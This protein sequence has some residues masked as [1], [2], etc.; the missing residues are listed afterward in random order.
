MIEKPFSPDDPYGL[1]P[2]DD[3]DVDLASAPVLAGD[4]VV[5]SENPDGSV[6]IEY[7][8][9]EDSTD[10]PQDHDA[11]LAESLPKE[12][13]LEIAST[14]VDCVDS[15]RLGRKDWEEAYSSGMEYLGIKKADR[16]KPWVGASG[17]YHPLLMEAVVRFQSQAMQEIFP[18]AGPAKT[19]IL[20]KD[21]SRNRQLAI[22]VQDELNY[23]LTQKMPE[24]RPDTER[25]LFRL[26]LSGSCFRKIYY[27][28]IRRRPRSMF[29]PA[30]DFIV[31]S[32]ES[33]LTCA[34]RYTHVCRMSAN[35]MI[36]MQ[37]M[38]YYL[39]VDLSDP[40]HESDSIQDKKGEITGHKPVSP[41]GDVHVVYECHIDLDLGED[42]DGVPLP[43]VVCVHKS[44]EKVL[45]IRRNWFEGDESRQRCQCFVSYEYVPG[46]GFYGL[47][48]IHLIGGIASSATSILRQLI[49]AGTLANLPAGLKS[50][51]LRIKGEDTPLRPGEFR[52]VDVAN[53]KVADAISF[54]PY[55]EPSAVLY[56]LLQQLVDEGRR[57]GSIADVDVGDMSGENPVGTTLALLE[58]AQKVMSAVQ[59]RLHAALA[60]ELKLIAEVIKDEMPANYDYN[61]G[62]EKAKFD[63]RKDF[64]Q[65][66]VEIIPVSDPG[67]TTMAQR[68]VQHQAAIQMASQAPQLYDMPKLHRAGLEILGFKD[69]TEMVPSA[70]D[71][72]PADPV[73][74]NANAMQGKPIR[75]FEHQDHEAHIAVHMAAMQDPMLQQMIGQSPQAAQIAAAMQAHIAEHLGFHYKKQ[76]EDLMGA[77]LPDQEQQMTP[78]MEAQIARQAVPAAKA[79]LQQ[80]QQQEA[81][82]RAQAIA[83]DP[84]VQLQQ[85]ELA[86]KE[87]EVI[88]KAETDMSK[89]EIDAQKAVLKANVEMARIAAQQ[90]TDGARIGA[91]VMKAAAKLQADADKVNSND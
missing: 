36:R 42:P 11:N 73:S 52:D 43:Y 47:G 67:A 5:V 59:A 48:M 18:P 88:R 75:A 10:L 44:D 14:V 13:L 16:D 30:E 70:E 71:M 63:R 58:R 80:N 9:D 24:Y 57:V 74:E 26:A 31:P 83:A 20:G 27:D 40:I 38:G 72:K 25:L 85:K 2:E 78:E 7:G 3:I 68:V 69:A 82:Q 50:R 23:Q 91:E 46:M 61:P 86:I 37:K 49:D 77:Q 53:G 56:Q 17:V 66:A 19:R 41:E 32:G 33:D 35:D 90:Q 34:E 39:D 81:Q 15:D 54:L 89:M 21:N 29:I 4:N 12:K 28:P 64:A 65:A 8:E 87:A 84:L 79:L 45:S 22:R 51:T 55:K 1:I 62:G 76:V 60:K 6:D